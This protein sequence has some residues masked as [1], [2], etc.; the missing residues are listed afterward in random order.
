MRKTSNADIRN[1][2][3]S[4]FSCT[5]IICCERE[6]IKTGVSFEIGNSFNHN[7]SPDAVYSL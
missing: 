1:A 6:N 5:M 4:F 2:I 7:W 3:A